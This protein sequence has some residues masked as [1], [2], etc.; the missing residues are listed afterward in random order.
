MMPV[1]RI[2]AAFFISNLIEVMLAA[3]P[4]GYTPLANGI[5]CV[6]DMGCSMQ[7]APDYK[8]IQTTCCKPSSGMSLS[9][10]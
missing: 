6:S 5:P 4:T 2:A 1:Y 10:T 8:C 7:G 3:C 9:I